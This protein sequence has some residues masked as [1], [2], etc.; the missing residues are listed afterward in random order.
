MGLGIKGAELEGGD[1]W[2]VQKD[3]PRASLCPPQ[4]KAGSGDTCPSVTGL[5]AR[6][7][8]TVSQARTTMAARIDTHPFPFSFLPNTLEELGLE[9]QV[10]RARGR[11]ESV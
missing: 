4:Q 8:A 2:E 1:L 11:R 10:A 6:E 7:A 9:G 5:L 3:P